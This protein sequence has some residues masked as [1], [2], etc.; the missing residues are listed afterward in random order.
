MMPLGQPVQDSQSGNRSVSGMYRNA[1]LK[2]NIELRLIYNF[3][4]EN[5]CDRS[6]LEMKFFGVTNI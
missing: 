4:R 1:G 2:R 5:N 6:A 3:F